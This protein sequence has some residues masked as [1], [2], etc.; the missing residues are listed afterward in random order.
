MTEQEESDQQQQ[1]NVNKEKLMYSPPTL[2]VLGTMKDV[3]GGGPGVS[4]HICGCG[5]M[6]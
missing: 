2:T 4:E 6:S 5:I 1:T 3:K